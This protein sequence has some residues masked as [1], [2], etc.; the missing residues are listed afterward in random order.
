[1]A[2][3]CNHELNEFHELGAGL[4][5]DVDFVAPGEKQFGQIVDFGEKL[6]FHKGFH[7]CAE[8]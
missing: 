7:K 4:A 2:R 6:V 1:M 3:M 8:Y 5:D